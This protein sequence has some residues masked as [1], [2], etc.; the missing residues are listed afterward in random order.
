MDNM[1]HKTPIIILLIAAI[2]AASAQT[3]TAEDY[4]RFRPVT[5]TQDGY[6]MRDGDRCEGI[7]SVEH[8]APPMELTSL[9]LHYD[10]FSS[11]SPSPI[12]L[13]WTFESDEDLIIAGR[14]HRHGAYYALD[15]VVPTNNGEF[16]WPADILVRRDFRR[17]DLGFLAWYTDDLAR[18]HVPVSVHHDSQVA[19]RNAGGPYLIGIRPGNLLSEVFVKVEQICDDGRVRS[20]HQRTELGRHY[21]SKIG[22]S[23]L[24]NNP[25]PTG[26]Y[27]LTLDSKIDN[28]TYST[29]SLAFTFEHIDTNGAA[30]CE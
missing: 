19:S 4:C 14:G 24:L 15:T 12:R 28:E 10:S 29:S 2:V 9:T 6:R 27:L 26:R 3:I 20:V 1:S 7:R 17:D 18:I 11:S 23:F 25:G 16:S 13:T 8:S 22:F 21:Y 30:S 5:N